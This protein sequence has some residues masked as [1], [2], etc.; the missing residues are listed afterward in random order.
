M[1]REKKKISLDKILTVSIFIVLAIYVVSLLLP[2]GWGLLTSL[3][4]RRDF[5]VLG[6]ILGFPNLDAAI[7]R[8]T[9][10]KLS[11][12]T[13]LF[14]EIKIETSVGF[15]SGLN[16]DV[17]VEHSVN[18]SILK[19]LYNTLV[20]AI[21]GSLVSTSVTMWVA[22]LCAKYK[23]KFSSIVYSVVLIT[24]AV[25]IVGTSA[26][27]I[28]LLRRLGMYDT[29]WG[30]MIQKFHFTGMY[31]LLFYAFFEAIP[32]TYSEAAEI[33]GASQL[34]VALKI[35]IPLSSTIFTTVVLI[36]FIGLW[37]DFS[38]ARL[39]LPT[40]PTIAYAIYEFTLGKY[41]AQLNKPVNGNPAP[42]IPGKIAFCMLLALPII[43]LFVCLRNK[44]MGNIN[45]GGIKG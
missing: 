31:F 26:S 41:A 36:H 25:P 20:Y 18:A 4:S 16:L 39:Y 9:F 17:A 19:M 24:M 7:S 35:I 2:L 27:T 13:F 1:K 28:T 29:L 23:F 33:D 5:E 3:K 43:I 10:F 38:T 30:N 44:I 42:G 22:Y 21:L 8:D 37:N 40:H 32:D 45:S 11:N 6:N 15:F 14:R 12:Y 34:M